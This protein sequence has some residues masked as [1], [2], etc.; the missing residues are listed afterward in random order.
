[1]IKSL[2]E[3]SLVI[4]GNSDPNI[5]LDN[6]RFLSK[7]LNVDLIIIDNEGHLNQL[8]GWLSLRQCLEDLTKMIK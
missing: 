4:H 1:M 2:Y 5:P 7:K 6:A 3:K 8:A